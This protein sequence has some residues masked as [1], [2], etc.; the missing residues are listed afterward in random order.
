MGHQPELM[1]DTIKE[2]IQLGEDQSIL[3][4]LSLVCMEEDILS[5]P[6]GILTDVGNSGTRLSGGQQSRTAL[7]RTLYHGK[8]IIILD[9]PFS[10]IDKKTEQKI[11][12]NLRIIGKD[13]IIILISH[14]LGIFP[15]LDQMIWLDGEHTQIGNH[16]TQMHTNPNYALLYKM[17]TLGGDENEAS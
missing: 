15:Q 13:K 10:A 14:R 6:D 7:A 17:Q 2:N 12:E 11:M 5:M 16:E 8:Q 3:S 9:D 1:S 4:V